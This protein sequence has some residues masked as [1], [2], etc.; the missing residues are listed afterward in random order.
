MKSILV[1]VL[2]IFVCGNSSFADSLPCGGAKGKAHANGGGF[3][4]ETA[5]VTPTAFVGS[6][7][8]VCDG[9]KV[10]GKARIEDQAEVGR[11]GQVFGMSGDPGF[12]HAGCRELR[13]LPAGP[14]PTFGNH[15]ARL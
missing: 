13:K 3:V 12:R 9:A 10:F 14:L 11:S 2:A 7:A 4:A 1:V 5:L 6:M 8:S 15:E